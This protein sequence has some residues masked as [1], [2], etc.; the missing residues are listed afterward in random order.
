MEENLNGWNRDMVKENITGVF[1][2]PDE[3]EDGMR[4]VDLLGRRGLDIENT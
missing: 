4:S 2:I 3:N 1:G